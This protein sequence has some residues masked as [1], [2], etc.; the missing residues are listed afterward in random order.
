MAI[1]RRDFLLRVGQ[2][3][4]FSAAFTVMQTLG[5]MPIPEAEAVTWNPSPV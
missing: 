3:G 4:G 2:A 1:T 5:L